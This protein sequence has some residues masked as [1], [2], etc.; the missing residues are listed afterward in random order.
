MNRDS[1][2]WNKSDYWLN[3]RT[4]PPLCQSVL[5]STMKTIS[6]AATAVWLVL[7][8]TYVFGEEKPNS[9]DPRQVA[10]T[11]GRL[12]EQGHYS[13]QKLDA[14]MEQS[15]ARLKFAPP[16][17]DVRAVERIYRGLCADC[18]RAQS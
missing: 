18:A 6:I 7:N 11:V 12:L 9:A 14:E 13:R 8:S 15:F 3:T 1:Q 16:G 17:F 2:I 5:W 4:L 10:I